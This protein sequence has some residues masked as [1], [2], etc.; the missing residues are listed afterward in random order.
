[1]GMFEE[2][3]F[4]QEGKLVGRPRG[5]PDCCVVLGRP[6]EEARGRTCALFKRLSQEHQSELIRT[7][8]THGIPPQVL[9]IPEPPN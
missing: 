2:M 4:T 8:E 9:G 3:T 7:L 6:S 1:M 5:D